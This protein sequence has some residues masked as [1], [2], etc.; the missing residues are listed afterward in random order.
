MPSLEW[1]LIKSDLNLAG[2]AQEAASPGCRVHLRHV[3]LR[4][5][6][7]TKPVW[8]RPFRAWRDGICVER[9]FLPLPL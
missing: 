9:V 7:M 1:P 2:L 5:P 6:G 8:L 3:W 4:G